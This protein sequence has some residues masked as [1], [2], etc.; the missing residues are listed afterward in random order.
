MKPHPASSRPITAFVRSW[1]A[2]IC[3]PAMAAAPI[4]AG[5]AVFPQE[6]WERWE[7]PE[8]AGFTTGGLERI[9]SWLKAQDTT[10]LVITIN[11]KIA[12]EHGDTERVSYVASVR[13]SI[14]AMLYGIYHD[15]G[16]IDLDLTLAE[17][18]I[19]D[20]QSL[21]DAE[22]RATAR[23]LILSKSGV[24][25]PASNTG[26]NLGDAPERGSQ[27]PGSYFLYSNWDFN[28]AGT[29][30]ET[31][32]GVNLFDALDQELARPLGMRHFD[33]DRHRKGGNPDRS[34]HPS[35][36][37]H[38]STLDMARL[39]HLALRE[40]NWDGRQLISREWMRKM[41][42]PLTPAAEINPESRR[43]NRPWAGYGFMW[44]V[45]DGD[46]NTGPF[47]GAYAAT[48]FRGQFITVLPAL[49]MVI[50][51]KTVLEDGNRVNSEDFWEFLEI[52]A[53]AH[54]KGNTTD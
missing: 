15:R 3:L 24:Y 50:A 29:V 51:H 14:L 18:G 7:S 26:D 27:E 23:H 25:H 48:G 47:K 10:G 9:E 13:K 34:V 40:G 53:K 49:D 52:V 45:W 46:H 37:M 16:E 2:A 32:T 12:Y 43:E 4:A 33:R 11:G 19:D 39:G 54:S 22:K 28:A 41:T 20:H 36:H 35:Y 42:S 8:A 30:F 31:Q 17:M 44:W 6:T 5:E 1:L 38:F 21:S